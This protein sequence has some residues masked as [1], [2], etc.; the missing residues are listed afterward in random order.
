MTAS[1]AEFFRT[2]TGYEPYPYQRRL[3][4]T[5]L[6]PRVLKAPTGAGKTAAVLLAW[7]WRRRFHPDPNVRNSTPRRLVYCLPM[8]VLVEQTRDA[9]E[10]Y[11]QRLGLRSSHQGGVRPD[12]IGVHILMGGERDEDW[13]LYP[14]RECV[15]IGT[16]DLL[17]SRALNRG[18][19]LSRFRWPIPFGLLN[20]DALWIFDEVQ[21]MGVAVP[22]SA[23]LEAFRRAF[24][25]VGPAATTWM[26]AT[27][28]RTWLETVD[29]PAP[30]DEEWLDLDDEDHQ[31]PRLAPRLGA[32]KQLK[33]LRL[34]HGPGASAY[35]AEVADSAARLHRPGTLTLV[36]VN[37][38]A[39]AQVIYLELRQ[40]CRTSAELVLLHSRFR[41]PDR[42]ARGARLLA[43][44]DPHGPGRIAVCTQV[45]EAGVDVSAA[46]LITELSPWPSMVQRFGRVN[47]YAEYPNAHV[48]WIDV[49]M[50]QAAPYA[51]E[52]L[53]LARGILRSLEGGSV[54][55]ATL[56][57][58]DLPREEHEVLRRRDLI[59]LFDTAPDLSGN[60]VD[61][62]RFV[63][64]SRETEVRVC[65]RAWAGGEPPR[66]WARVAP[67]ELCPV[68]IG[69]LRAWLA[70]AGRE[71]WCWDHLA[72][73]WRRI[74]PSELWPGQVV[75]LRAEHGG[76]DPELGWSADHGGSVVPCPPEGSEP[77]EAGGDDVLTFAPGRWQSL[78]EHSAE[79][80]LEVE[81]L[82]AA[83][84]NPSLEPFA[85]DL[86]QAARFH[87][88][89]KAHPVF[90]ETL[91]AQAS[92]SERYAGT[93]WAKAERTA[94]PGPHRRPHFRHELA[95][96]LALLGQQ[97]RGEEPGAS[98][99]DLALYLI[100]SHHGRVRLTVRNL[101]GP[102][103]LP[104]PE[105]SSRVLLGIEDGE[106]L[107]PAEVDH[108][109]AL[110]EVRLELW[111][112]EIG[113]RPQGRSWLARSLALRDRLGPFRLAYLEALLRAADARASL[114]A[115]RGG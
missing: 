49:P 72:R 7:I 53:H 27:L 66:D 32:A 107:P 37:T 58:P 88:W 92:D 61:V 21:L 40:R 39:R 90:Q 48:Y 95:S 81:A 34:R 14:E 65:W 50:G 31:D 96:L 57:H 16:Q 105:T 3:A 8:R 74:S 70:K 52:A 28:S 115:A 98:L 108:G 102:D 2:A 25:T 18:Y 43:P 67:D 78:A 62:S 23:Q 68:P 47:R 97:A 79:V 76:Y 36:I 11:L 112:V 82:L 15:L 71:A 75:V 113:D 12:D 101:P 93:V 99:G 41:P 60:D 54:A 51:P 94:R 10:D 111:P 30:P 77:E 87:D 13:H 1:F 20:N 89:G 46:L 5:P 56:P 29:H 83:L 64:D 69:E 24:G 84:Q 91:L 45:L 63:R 109:L 86:L 17:L 104:Y 80:V 4:D 19:V 100:A 114:R 55:P 59:D 33:Q 103:G 85:V 44:V 9:V 35:A 73:T 106:V 6:W 38:V 110:P 26:S 22:T 42:R